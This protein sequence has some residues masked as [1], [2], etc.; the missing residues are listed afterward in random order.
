MHRSAISSL[1]RHAS[2]GHIACTDTDTKCVK[3]PAKEV[4]DKT[5]SENDAA[6]DHNQLVCKEP[7][8]IGEGSMPSSMT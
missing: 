1:A 4:G 6:R 3:D 2:V 8:P 5:V 7:Q